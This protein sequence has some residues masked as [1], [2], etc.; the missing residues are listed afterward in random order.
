MGLPQ[1]ERRD[2]ETRRRKAMWDDLLSRGGPRNVAP[3]LLR[4]LGI[5]G[6]AAGVWVNSEVTRGVSSDQFGVAVSVLHNGHSYN[7]ELSKD[8]IIYRFPKTRRWPS[9]DASETAALRNAYSFNVPIFVVT[10]SPYRHAY[11]DVHLGKVVAID[12]T[13]AHCRVE[14][15][16]YFQPLPSAG[17][18]AVSPDMSVEQLRGT[19]L[20]LAE[21]QEPHVGA[22]QRLWARVKGGYRATT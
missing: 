6:G 18:V 16:A 20:A 2:T 15:G 5:Y 10:H 22:L 3:A 1:D 7:D 12:E 11:R 19:G 8:G 17:K 9:R 21:G 4:E 13:A 14:F